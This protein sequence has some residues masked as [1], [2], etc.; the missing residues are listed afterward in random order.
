MNKEYINKSVCYIAKSYDGRPSIVFID[1]IAEDMA[2]VKPEPG[3][4]ERASFVPMTNLFFDDENLFL[5]LK[6]AY[7][8]RNRKGLERLWRKAH[9]L[10]EAA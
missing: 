9:P 8:S 4:Y 2:S 5:Q 7:E 6:S 1:E 3:R 10:K